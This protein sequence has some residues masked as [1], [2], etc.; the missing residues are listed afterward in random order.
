MDR[1][2]QADDLQEVPTEKLFEQ[3][4]HVLKG[5]MG[6]TDKEPPHKAADRNDHDADWHSRKAK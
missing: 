5:L 6:G 4:E 1:Q 2:L 3:I